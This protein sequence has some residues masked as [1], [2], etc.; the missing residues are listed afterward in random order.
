MAKLLVSYEA[1]RVHTLKWTSRIQV[2]WPA[3]AKT[4]TVPFRKEH[5]AEQG[6]TIAMRE[7]VNQTDKDAP[8]NLKVEV[9]PD[10]TK[11]ILSGDIVNGSPPWL[12]QIKVSMER[13]SKPRTI[14]RG[15]V[16]LAV[17]LNGSVAIPMQPLDAGWEMI[18]KQV[19]LQLWDGSHKVW[20]G[21]TASSEMPITLKNQ[22]CLVSVTPQSDS[23]LVRISPVGPIRPV[24]FQRT[25]L[26]PK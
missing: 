21:N 9:A 17:N 6:H 23:M 3:D 12:A 19:T 2:T 15:E 8:R 5:I 16:A 20:E 11:F 24:S 13:R 25:P 4:A 14:N 18:R 1:V 7:L 22:P 10:K 26:L